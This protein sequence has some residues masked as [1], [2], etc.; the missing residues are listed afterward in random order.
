M[1]YTKDDFNVVMRI[2]TTGILSYN[3]IE[4]IGIFKHTYEIYN[5]CILHET[6]SDLDILFKM[7]IRCPNF[8]QIANIT[9]IKYP[10]IR[11]NLLYNH[12]SSSIITYIVKSIIVNLERIKDKETCIEQIE[13]LANIIK[14][15]IDYKT[16]NYKSDYDID[17]LTMSEQLKQYLIKYQDNFLEI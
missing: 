10:I 3:Q 1:D 17:K 16:Y 15:K 2:L 4:I 11:T 14:N 6:D 12:C 5:M 13:L 7:F 9:K 8:Q